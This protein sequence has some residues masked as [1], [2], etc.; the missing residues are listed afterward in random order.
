MRPRQSLA[1]RSYVPFFIALFSCGCQLLGD[2]ASRDQERQKVA[3][4]DARQA[5]GEVLGLDQSRRERL[6]LATSGLLQRDGEL[7]SWVLPLIASYLPPGSEVPKRVHLA[8]NQVAPL[9]LTLDGIKID[10]MAPWWEARS[11]WVGVIQ[12]LYLSALSALAEVAPPQGHVEPETLEAFSEV[13]LDQLQR[14]GMASF[15]AGHGVDAASATKDFTLF[16]PRQQVE[17]RVQ[18]LQLVLREVQG[19]LAPA[20]AWSQLES[21]Q[22]RDG[23]IAVTG[24]YMAKVIEARLGK[25]ALVQL[26][27]QGPRAFYTAYRETEPGALVFVPLPVPSSPSPSRQA[28]AH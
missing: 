19:G 20:A 26:V 13:L 17:A 5:Q 9:I 3:L 12:G 22:R 25:A 11:Q 7:E 10:V 27:Q 24:A 21:A 16:M 28:T 1:C 14:L 2:R 15:V 8:V 6:E 23:V 18:V 4:I